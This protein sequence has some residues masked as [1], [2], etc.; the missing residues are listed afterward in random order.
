MKSLPSE[1]AWR[2]VAWLCVAM[3][4]LLSVVHGNHR[5]H[6]GL[7]G[8]LEHFAAY[9]ATGFIFRLGYGAARSG[10]AIVCGLSILS[11]VMEI[12]QT[13]I[14]GRSPNVL[15]ALSSTSGAILGL[16]LALFAGRRWRSRQP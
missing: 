7:S 12:A 3:I 6:T 15:D 16:L 11:V 4:I 10:A 2:A 1:P 8:K 5:P 14:P 13:Q 9:T